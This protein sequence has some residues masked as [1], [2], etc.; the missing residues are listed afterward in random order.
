L[1]GIFYWFLKRIRTAQPIRGT[2]AEHSVKRKKS[3]AG[4]RLS[5][6]RFVLL[7]GDND[8]S[9]SHGDEKSEHDIQ[10]I[11]SFHHFSPLSMTR[12]AI[13]NAEKDATPM[14]SNS[15]RNPEV[16]GP[17]ISVAAQILDRSNRVLAKFSSWR[18]VNFIKST[19]AAWLSAVNV[20][21]TPA[22]AILFT[23]LTPN[24]S[25]QTPQSPQAFTQE[26]PAP[27]VVQQGTHSDVSQDQ[28][29]VKALIERI[30]TNN[31]LPGAINEFTKTGTASREAYSLLRQIEAQALNQ[32]V[33]DIIT[34]VRTA[35]ASIDQAVINSLPPYDSQ[36]L[37]VIGVKHGEEENTLRDE[38]YILAKQGKLVLALENNIYGDAENRK[39]V[40]D[41]N[42]NEYVVGSET[43]IPYFFSGLLEAYSL[44]A[45]G[46]D[47]GLFY[48]ADFILRTKKAGIQ[49]ILIEAFDA[50]RGQAD[51]KVNG[52]N[53]YDLFEL[54]FFNYFIY[55]I[56]FNFFCRN[57]Y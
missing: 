25:A 50:V 27:T 5:M 48:I 14:S 8:S 35:M 53:F 20:L 10:E 21:G 1:A 41:E 22:L 45:I 47:K 24:L 11:K 7:G 4:E 15:I 23:A 40:Y 30:R 55:Q 51:F 34:K 33:M 19:I 3:E 39:H 29:K 18:F 12:P 13:R 26:Q 37:I 32:G 42:N 57:Y 43:E 38:L 17:R 54:I 46:S 16:N 9:N 49:N 44:Y 36:S 52:Y 2:P 28:Q 6:M 31:N 56:K